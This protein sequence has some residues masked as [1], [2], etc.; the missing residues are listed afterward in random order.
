MLRGCRDRILP[1]ALLS[2]L[3]PFVANCSTPDEVSPFDPEDN[4]DAIGELAGGKVD[5][6]GQY[7]SGC[8]GDP[9]RTGVYALRG[10]VVKMLMAMEQAEDQMRAEVVAS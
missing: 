1:Y 6:E 5:A 8:D 10:D 7:R 9:I 2:A 4:D 3:T